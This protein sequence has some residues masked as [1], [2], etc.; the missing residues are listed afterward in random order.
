MS[1]FL[2]LEIDNHPFFHVKVGYCEI[3]HFI[4]MGRTGSEQK[5][6]R[7]STDVPFVPG[8]KPFFWY[9]KKS[10]QKFKGFLAEE[11]W[12]FCKKLI[13][14]QQGRYSSFQ[15]NLITCTPLLGERDTHYPTVLYFPFFLLQGQAV[16]EP[17]GDPA[18][19]ITSQLT[20]VIFSWGKNPPRALGGFQPWEKS[21]YPVHSSGSTLRSERMGD[22]YSIQGRSPPANWQL[23]G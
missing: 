20:G 22:K 18:L 1:R 3:S 13:R 12:F 2:E 5:A 9:K 14:Y 4:W 8:E 6:L 19:C 23:Q 11:K 16:R 21:P 7:P 15:S 10:L 17:C